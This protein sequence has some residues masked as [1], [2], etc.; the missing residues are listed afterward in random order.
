[1]TELYTCTEGHEVQRAANVVERGSDQAAQLRVHRAFSAALDQGWF[2]GRCLL[3][4]FGKGDKE[5]IS[6]A[7]T[8][9]LAKRAGGL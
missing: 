5:N 4:V 3:L 6:K 1:M 7:D 8:N 2:D 9:A